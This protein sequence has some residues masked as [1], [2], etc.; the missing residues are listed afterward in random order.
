MYVD[1]LFTEQEQGFTINDDNKADW[2]I[3]KIKS[4]RAETERLK[5]IALNQI[6]ELQNKLV[7]LDRELENKTAF[8]MGELNKYF[9]TVDEGKK[10]TKTQYSYKLL[11]G[12]IYCKKPTKKMNKTDDTE[13]IEYLQRSGKDEF[14]KVKSTLDWAEYK[15]TLAIAGDK[16]I[17]SETGEIIPGIEVEDIPETFEIK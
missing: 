16:V 1:E 7:E 9:D 6:V 11:S 4:E 12:T 14:I 17:D 3:K 5:S 8:L 15:K 10:E 13:I 2:A